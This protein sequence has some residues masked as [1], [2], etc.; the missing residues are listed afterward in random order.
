MSLARFLRHKSVEQLQAEVGQR[1]DFRR[2]LGLWQLTAIGIGGIIGVGIFVLA[3]QQA[4]LN[5]GP[6]VALSF[7]IAGFGSAC[8]ALCYAEFAGLIPVTGSAYT[9]GYAVLGEGAAWIIGWDLLLEY[10]LVVAVVAIGWSGYVQVLLATA[11]VHLPEW[12]QKSMSA[13]TMKYYWQ[14]AMG[15][16]GVS[17][18]NPVAA[19]TDG[20]RFN[21]I[22]AG[23]SLLVAILLSVRTEWG[24]RLN[25]LIVAIKVLGVALV[26]GVGA[27]FINTAN[28]H[29]FIPERIF[30][31]KGVGHFGWHGV[32]T[33]ASV[34]FFAVF[35]YDT[36]TT[37]AEEARNPQRDLPR[38]VLLSLA[39]AM[40]LYIAVSLVLT[41][42]VPYA[43]LSGEASVSD[44][45]NAIGLP[46]IS[47]VIA[48]AAVIGVI[49]VLFAFMLGAAR[50]WFALARDG[51]LPAW[52]A[53]VHPRFG[54]PARPT[55]ILG[56]FT[57][58]VAG[59]L[60]IGEV[61]ELVNI[62][63]LS[64]FILICASVLVLR[65]RKPGL[66]R[67]FR[68]PAVW[69]V[70]PL[71]ILF[72]LALIWGLPW[73]TFERFAIW[74]AIGLIVYFTYGVRHSKLNGASQ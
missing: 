13:D 45:F 19:P 48:V 42:I 26:I 15:S 67:K 40:V 58:I 20:H 6:A 51:L 50:I 61:A 66:E 7:I 33:G 25:T 36:L 4:A 34:V 63:T 28:W 57:A 16:L 35:G 46:W 18:A 41:G 62:G 17:Y 38:A 59:L 56:I 64:A 3:G 9:Y 30:D 27:F 65:V 73:I 74:M 52:F 47:N 60:P 54:T 53:R 1:K 39:V 71:G 29:P 24:A 23:I 69:F 32:L 68:T 72:S 55:M 49:S 10:A 37:A 2:V 21:V 43:S 14:H 11:G 8:A 31:D 22:A 44:A 12:A 70:A 5:A